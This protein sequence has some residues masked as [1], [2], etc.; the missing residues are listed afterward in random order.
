MIRSSPPRGRGRSQS[1]DAVL[2]AA[3]A[4]EKNKKT[5]KKKGSQHADVID[6]LDFTGIGAMVHHDGP[7]DACAPSRNRH[8][9]KAPMLAWRSHTGDDGPYAAASAFPG[10]SD[11]PRRTVDA[12]AEAWGKHEPEPFEEFSAGGGTGDRDRTPSSSI[13]NGVAPAPR[14]A[15]SSRREPARDPREAY[16]EMVENATRTTKRTPLP[17]P[18]PIFTAEGDQDPERPLPSPPLGSSSNGPKRSKSLM[19]RLRRVRDAPN[20][21]MD[22][23]NLANEMPPTP[24]SPIADR[25]THRAQQSSFPGRYFADRGRQNS[26]YSDEGKDGKGAATP[27]EQEELEY[28]GQPG[29]GYVGAASPSGSTGM[30]RKTSILGRVRGAV[31]GN[32]RGN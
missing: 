5:T 16:R 15:S 21:P 9:Q 3:Q 26:D 24:T 6:R 23:E 11:S 1:H 28:F 29:S 2:L 10:A 13:Y 31:T 25:P 14:S 30:G 12:I 18:Q 19:Q 7:F 32:R 4:V 8:R 17:P 22:D 20:V 27:M